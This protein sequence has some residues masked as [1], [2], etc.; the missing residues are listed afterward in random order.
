MSL[1][2]TFKSQTEVV[3]DPKSSIHDLDCDSLLPY[4]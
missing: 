3:T 1:K 4:Q 2:A